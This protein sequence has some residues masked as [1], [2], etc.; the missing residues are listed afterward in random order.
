MTCS[1][2]LFK[3]LKFCYQTRINRKLSQH[4]FLIFCKS[5]DFFFFK[6]WPSTLFSYLFFT[7]VQNLRQKKKRRFVIAC[8]FEFSNNIVT[9]W[10]NYILF[11]LRMM[12]AITIFVGNIFIF[13]FVVMDWSQSQLGWVHIWGGGREKKLS[14]DE[15]ESLTTKLGWIISPSW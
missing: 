3:H 7:L 14:K 4:D 2:N 15:C 9:F 5:N 13:S 8:V 12:G 1:S 10:K 11:F 6:K